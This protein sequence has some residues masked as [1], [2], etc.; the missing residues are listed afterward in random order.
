MATGSDPPASNPKPPVRSPRRG[1]RGKWSPLARWLTQKENRERYEPGMRDGTLYWDEVAEWAA[2]DGIT[3]PDGTPWDRRRMSEAYNDLRK[4]GL[5]DGWNT[6]GKPGQAHVPVASTTP[7]PAKPTESDA[8]P[9]MV[10]DERANVAG[11]N[12]RPVAP[13]PTG[14][15]RPRVS[16]LSDMLNR[17]P[18]LPKT[19]HQARPGE[20]LP[21]PWRGDRTRETDDGDENQSDVGDKE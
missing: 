11:P 1:G 20:E 10:S 15:A 21:S 9:G 2:K 5:L 14:A 16:D 12:P 18:P 6:V 3:R 8:S 4:R 17:A 13:P 7:V 19:R